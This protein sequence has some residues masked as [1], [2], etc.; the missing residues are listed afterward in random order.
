MANS[1]V[2]YTGNAVT[3]L[4]SVPFPYLDKA[5]VKA[6]VNGVDAVFRWESPNTVTIIPTPANGATVFI[7]RNTPKDTPLIDFQDGVILTETDLDI[8]FLQ[9]FY[10]CQELTDK[11]EQVINDAAVRVAT[12]SGIITTPSANIADQIVAD[13]VESGLYTEL[14][15]RI[16]DL[17]ALGEV[18]AQD[19]VYRTNT[20]GTIQTLT[21]RITTLEENGGT[22]VETQASIDAL[23]AQ[24][25]V[26]IDV[27]GYVAG[28]GLAAYTNNDGT[29]TSSFVIRADTFTIVAPGVTP[30]VP[31]TAGVVGG[32]S[33]VGINGQ[34]IVDGTIYGDSIAAGEIGATHI[35]TNNLAAINA[36]LGVITAGSITFDYGSSRKFEIDKTGSY[37]VWYGVGAKNDT[38]GIFY[39]K[40][41][42]TAKFKG[43]IDAGS[44]QFT[45]DS[46][47]NVEAKSI[48]IRDSGNNIILSSGGGLGTSIVGNT[49]LDRASANKL[50]VGE[51]DIQGN[52]VS[53]SAAAVTAGQVTLPLY[54]WT[55]IQT[56]NTGVVSTTVDSKILASFG[57]ELEASSNSPTGGAVINLR[58]L[59]NGSVVYGPLSAIYGEPTAFS[60]VSAATMFTLPAGQNYSI[61]L[62][63]DKDYSDN[64]YARNRYI[65]TLGIKK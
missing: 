4:F 2:E 24:Y 11:Y 53:L 55:T 5:H 30:V 33:T 9:N 12:G 64:G 50:S 44:G 32:V 22:S 25:T 14:S 62:Q 36:D 23:K 41:D 26:K 51:L 27:D 20:D 34:L 7:S 29:H 65:N 16:A 8:S 63:V 56:L 46:A 59:V 31:F 45:V 6:S 10:L 38:N 28:Y 54:T 52:A 37:P 39:V 61:Q 48:T 40:T 1:Y 17:D 60:L 3:N 35:T 19:A 57:A 42:G 13:V 18:V 49:Q 43:A 15:T 58:L 21:S 47:G